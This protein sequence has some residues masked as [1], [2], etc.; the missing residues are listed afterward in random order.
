M[1][2]HDLRTEAGQIRHYAAIKARL[3]KKAPKVKAANTNKVEPIIHIRSRKPVGN[4]PMWQRTEINFSAH[5]DNWNWYRA[6]V[7]EKPAKRYLVN[8]A[9]NLGIPYGSLIGV[10]RKQPFVHHRLI[11]MYVLRHD[12]GCS[13]P[14]IGRLLG[15]RDHSTAHSGISKIE[16]LLS[17]GLDISEYRRSAVE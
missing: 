11:A 12:F 3:Y 13:Y 5:L 15:G 17:E 8:L 14:E 4:A 7:L 6:S 2:A 9:A 1:H 16:R 10:T